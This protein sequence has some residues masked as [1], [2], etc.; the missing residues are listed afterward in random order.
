MNPNSTQNNHMCILCVL[1]FQNTNEGAPKPHYDDKTPQTKKKLIT[2]F[3]FNWV[4]ITHNKLQVTN[5]L[6][7]IFDMF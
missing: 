7:R 2:L 3:T 6:Q 1:E 5:V 4:L